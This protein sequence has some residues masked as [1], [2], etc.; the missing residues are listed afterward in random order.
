MN[1]QTPIL[2]VVIPLIF[3][4]LTLLL[5]WWKKVFC[6]SITLI[7]LIL[8]SLASLFTL[9]TVITTGTIHYHLGNWAPPW[10]IEYVIDHFNAFVLVIISLISLLAVIYSKKSVEQE[11][12]DKDVFFYTVFLLQVVGLLGIAITGDLFNL[13]VFLEIASLSA[14]ALIAVGEDGAPLASLKYVIIG[15]IGACFYLLG[16]G[17][18]YIITGSLNMGDLSN[19][20]PSLYSN[21]TVQTAFVFIIIGFGIKIALFPLHT[22]QPD[23]Y[24]YAPST[25]SVIISTAMAKTSIYALI[26]VIFSVFTIKFITAFAP[27]FDIICWISAVTMI[28]G[29]IYAI[30]QFN[31]KRMLAYSSIANVGYIMLGVGLANSTT[32]GLTPVVM[33]ILNHTLMK[34]CMFMTAGAFIFKAGLKDIRD[35]VGLGRKMPFTCF[36]FILAALAMIG[37]PP[38]VGFITKWY[39]ILA[40]LDAGNYIFVAVI[41]FSTLLMIVYFWRVIEIMYI[42]VE[43]GGKSEIKVDETPMSMLIPGLILA[44]LCIVTGIAW[45]SGIF[46]PIIEAINSG[47]GLGVMP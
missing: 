42:R 38:S 21:V 1:I 34:G 44:L 35:F 16:I 7:A 10:G 32:L 11:L 15:T 31:L 23:V 29:S 26:R 12:P 9:Y 37:M 8:S 40:A 46:T 28:I 45:I 39:L 19:L 43:D 6:Y 4:F 20:L 14:Y 17:Y 5:G 3:S 30:M 33:H 41:F 22:W 25:V 47:F 2:I 36:A 27:I 13:Y 18:L 24:T